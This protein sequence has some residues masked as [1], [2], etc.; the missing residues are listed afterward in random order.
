MAPMDAPSRLPILVGDPSLERDTETLYEALSELIRVYQFRDRDRICCYDISITQCYALEE[1]VRR[2]G[3]TLNE[4]AA[5]LYLD[6]STASRVVDALERKAYVE[7]VPHPQDRR[8][9]VLTPTPAGRTLYQTIRQGILDE[10]QK[11][12]ADFDPQVRQAMTQLIAR[13]ARAAAGRIEAGGGS[14]CRIS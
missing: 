10:E 6:K 1:L 11:L 3:M 14:C 4:L 7:R 9:V 12:L 8:A 5:H 2:E 13:L